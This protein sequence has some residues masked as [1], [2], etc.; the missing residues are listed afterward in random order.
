M[1]AKVSR[2]VLVA[3]VVMSLCLT[4]Q[5]KVYKWVDENGKV[6]YGERPPPGAK[7]QDVKVRKSTGSSGAA[8]VR[9]AER[10]SRQQKLL[11]AFE[12]DR[13]ER[14]AGKA[15]VREQQ[16]K[17]DELCARMKKYIEQEAN[18]Q[19]LY[20][21]DKKTGEKTVVSD[22]DRAANIAQVKERYRKSC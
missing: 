7:V 17:M 20:R 21:K 5:A 18:A 13:K 6:H 3:G 19:Y 22:A 12:D 1:Y 8:P 11:K 10:R 2:L 15:K 14:E 9:D 16:A 4:V